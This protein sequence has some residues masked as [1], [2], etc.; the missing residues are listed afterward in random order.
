QHCDQKARSRS[1]TFPFPCPASIS[2]AGNAGM[3]GVTGPASG[4]V[5]WRSWVAR[6]LVILAPICF[7]EEQLSEP[8]YYHASSLA[9]LRLPR[10]GVSRN[11]TPGDAAIAQRNCLGLVWRSLRCGKD[12]L[13]GP[14]KRAFGRMRWPP[15]NSN[16]RII[17][18]GIRSNITF[19]LRAW[20]NPF[21]PNIAAGFGRPPRSASHIAYAAA[22]L[23]GADSV[24]PAY[25][26]ATPDSCE[27]ADLAI[28][29]PAERPRPRR[30]G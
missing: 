25:R 27:S 10:T 3:G 6:I 23:H 24:R 26:L 19:G 1:P 14:V 12:N 20:V 8:K 18:D 15:L 5:F 7:R 29:L 30:Q 13:A 2:V 9:R 4:V 28:A 22:N 17:P 11:V 21:S 16:R